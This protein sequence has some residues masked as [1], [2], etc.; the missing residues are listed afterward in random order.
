MVC[1]ISDK[2][3]KINKIVVENGFRKKGIGTRLWDELLSRCREMGINSIEF[4]SS[5][6]NPSAITFYKKK[7]CIFTGTAI[8]SD[9]KERNKNKYV[10]KAANNITHSKPTIDISDIYSVAE[11]L[12][13]GSLAEGNLVEEFCSSL[14]SSTGRSFGIA[15]NSGTS[16]LYLALKALDVKIG[17]EVIIPSFTC[18]SLMAAVMQC[19]AKPVIADINE[20][21]YNISFAD[22]KKKISP[23]TKAIIL[24]H[25]FGKPIEDIDLFLDTGI[26]I[27][28]D[29][30]HAIGAIHDRKKIGSFGDISILSFYATKMITT[31]VGGAI[32]SDDTKIM[33]RLQDITKIDHREKAGE[34]YNYKMS[35]MQAALGLSQLERLDEFIE[36]RRAA[37][38]KYNE[39]FSNSEIDFQLPNI[40][41]ENVFFRYIIKHS[42]SDHLI[43]NVNKRGVDCS[44]P[45]YK[46]LHSYFN[47]D[48][49]F[50]NTANAFKQAVSVPI[51]P[52]I[53]E[54]EIED[55]AGIIVNWQKEAKI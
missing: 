44:R 32:L 50:P 47:S 27:I 31:G 38:K 15:V 55:A 34:S 1:S 33:D 24:P 9:G 4:K 25:M 14:C 20:H 54:Q 8:G 41:K 43:N 19:N 22:V 17:D 46:P 29:C 28:E 30:A 37:A 11:V 23:H 51:Y 35:D 49:H 40:D 16:A 39:L 2:V 26:P 7:S 12:K 10:I 53:T 42:H 21:D 18:Y 5:I 52:N 13:K 48:A 6:D 36:K 45:V 3:G